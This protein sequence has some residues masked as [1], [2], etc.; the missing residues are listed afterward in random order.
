MQAEKATAEGTERYRRRFEKKISGSHF[1]EIRDLAVSSIGLGTYLGEADA[2]TDRAYEEAI[3]AALE[4]GC[5]MIDTAINYRF[6]RSERNVGIAFQ[7]A[8]KAGAICRDELLIS[9]KGGFISFDGEYPSN[10]SRYFQDEFV[11][12]GIC[13]QEDLVAGCH[14][15]TPAYL[16]NQLQRSLKNLQVDCIDV[17]FIHNPETQLSEISRQDFLRRMLAAF[18]ILEKMTAEGK[19]QMYGTATWNGYREP[20]NSRSYLSLED[21]IGLA[22]DAG[23]EGHHFRAL[24]VPFNLAMPEAFLVKNQKFG[25]ESVSLLEAAARHRML[26]LC[27]ASILQGQ[28]SR[29]LPDFVTEFFAGLQT[30]AHRALQFVRSTRGVTSA[31][32]GMSQVRHVEENMKLAAQ[33]PLPWEKMQAL[34]S[35]G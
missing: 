30:D 4:R 2:D 7:R 34:F 35:D 17:Y 26:V 20:V 19:I 16:E 25:P 22:R 32:V 24:Q 3:F 21:L 31:L 11:K 1:V 33:P 5:N 15:M 8:L 29:N 28:L 13:A 10:P 18:R 6:Q 23:G 27:S 9:S 14:C 12:T